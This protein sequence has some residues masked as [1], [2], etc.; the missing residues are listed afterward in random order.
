LERIGVLTVAD[1]VNRDA[2]EIATRLKNRRVKEETVALWQQQARLM[3][4]IPQL[5]G[6]DAQVLIACGITEPEQLATMSPSDLFAIVGPFV[7]T[8]AGQRLLRSSNAPDL[9]EVADW[10]RWSQHS[11]LLRAA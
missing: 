8:K 5:R 3:C 9:A 7:E 6:H 10:I 11:R 4:R 2:G 1:L